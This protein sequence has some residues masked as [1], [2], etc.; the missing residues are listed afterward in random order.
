MFCSLFLA[1][2]RKYQFMTCDHEGESQREGDH[3]CYSR[4]LEKEL[5]QDRTDSEDEK[6][7][8]E[9]YLHRDQVHSVKYLFGESPRDKADQT[10]E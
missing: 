6:G 1:G 2:V 10:T 7:E 8:K 3:K 9:P 4:F 5:E